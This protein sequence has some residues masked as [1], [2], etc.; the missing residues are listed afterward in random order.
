M[1]N[2]IYKVVLQ[3]RYRGQQILNTLWYRSALEGTFATDL[4]IDGGRALGLSVLS[5]IWQA[6]WRATKPADYFLDAIAVSGYNDLLEVLYNNAQVVTPEAEHAMGTAPTS[7]QWMPPG[8]CVN[9]AFFM[10]NRLISN[11]LFKPPVK[12]LVAMSPI[13]ENWLGSDGT[14]NDLG[15]SILKPAADVLATNLPWDFIDIDIPFTNWQVGTGL[16]NAFIPLRAKTWQLSTPEV[17]GGVQF[18]KHIETTDVA[19]VVVRKNHGFRHTRKVE[20]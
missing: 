7:E 20:G 5:H 1:A 9:F 3:A 2:G 11:P 19:S 12:G 18:F 16:P 4:L 14:V 13:H 15:V 8:V 10:K 17:I 6:A